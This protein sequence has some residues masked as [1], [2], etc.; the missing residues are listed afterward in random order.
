MVTVVYI[1]WHVHKL[2][3]G[4]EN[5]KLVGVYATSE[6]ADA[7]RTRVSDAPGFREVP[8]GFHVDGYELGKDHW[9]EGY[10]TMRRGE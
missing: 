8:E 3:D 7:A 9:T 10:V 6:E 2:D 1:L 5:A 4:E